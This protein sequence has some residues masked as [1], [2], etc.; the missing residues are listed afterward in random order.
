VIKKL[1]LSNGKGREHWKGS[2]RRNVARFIHQLMEIAQQQPFIGQ[3]RERI[4][5]WTQVNVGTI[6]ATEHL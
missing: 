4:S 1:T 5:A 2:L 3:Q 6:T